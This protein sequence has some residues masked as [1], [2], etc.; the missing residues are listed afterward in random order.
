VKPPGAGQAALVRRGE[1]VRA[2]PQKSLGMP[3]GNMLQVALGADADPAA[4]DALEVGLAQPDL[5][6]NLHQVG[7]LL[8]MLLQVLD[9]LLDEPIVRGQIFQGDGRCVHGTSSRGG[10]TRCPY[11]MSLP[12]RFHPN[13]AQFAPCRRP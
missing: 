10:E 9:R 1:Q 3:Q 11:S 6:G 8:M 12:S 13:V 5:A 4:E 7:L 2:L